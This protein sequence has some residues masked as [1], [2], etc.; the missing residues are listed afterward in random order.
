MRLFFLLFFSGLLLFSACKPDDEMPTDDLPM[1][2]DL[3]DIPY[4]PKVYE[5]QIPEGLPNM[6]IPQDNP[7]TVDG[8]QLGRRLFY[9]PILSGDNTMACA[10]CHEPEKSFTDDLA[11]STGIDN[12]PGKRSSMSLLNIGFNREGFFWDGRSSTLEEQALLPVEDPIELHDDWEG[13]EEE[14]R[15]HELYPEL[16]RKAFGIS[17]RSEISKELAG[18]AIAQFERILIGS[19]NSKFDRVLR[20][21][22]FFTPD[23]LNGY[24]MYFDNVATLPDAECGHCHNVPLMTT[25]QY[26]N[27]G[28][29][30]AETLQ[31]FP[32]I[33]YGA[34]TGDPFDNG[35]FRIPTLRNISFTAPYMH[36]GR[37]ET[38]EEVIDH[39]NSGGK[40]SPNKNSLIYPLGMNEEQKRQLLAFI[41]TLDDP[42]FNENPAYKSP[43]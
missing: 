9:D 29:V 42:E 31:D 30:A 24:D 33:G 4:E 10:D 28:L 26:E 15:A 27:N 21:E 35:T 20:G 6:F 43:F 37:F 5:L 41:K 25:N 34:V 7:L 40:D 11:V 23:E 14:F 19:G 8:I 18:K 22:A 38:L 32:D 36:D 2:G 17:D 1:T 39:Y 3:E 16:F 13:V 12:I